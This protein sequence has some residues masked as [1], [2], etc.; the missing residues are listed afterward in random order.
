MAFVYLSGMV[1]GSFNGNVSLGPFMIAASKEIFTAEVF[2]IGNDQISHIK[3][4]LGTLIHQIG[5]QFS[6]SLLTT[7]LILFCGDFI[8]QFSSSAWGSEKW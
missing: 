7:S 1:C 3:R 2:V 5:L 4:H 8:D 6:G